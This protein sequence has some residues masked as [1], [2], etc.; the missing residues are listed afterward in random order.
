MEKFDKSITTMYLVL[1]DLNG[2]HLEWQAQQ[3]ALNDRIR[4]LEENN[5]LLS[6][7]NTE[8]TSKMKLLDSQLLECSKKLS[9]SDASITELHVSIFLKGLRIVRYCQ[10]PPLPPAL[11][12]FL[13]KN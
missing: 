4:S 12:L 9:E 8:I 13:P 5:K 3:K 7:Q 1:K 10:Y 11:S 6:A 2:T